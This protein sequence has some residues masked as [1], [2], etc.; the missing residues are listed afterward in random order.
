MTTLDTDEDAKKVGEFS[1]TDIRHSKIDR[2]MADTLFD[3]NYGGTSGNSHIAVGQSYA[4]S[5][6]G[7][8]AELTDELK[9]ELGFTESVVHWDLINTEDKTVTAVMKDGSTIV[10]YEN[11]MFAV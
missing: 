5:Y 11:G 3:E 10:I 8:Q 2:F 1:L 9:K 7:D 6:T 4:E